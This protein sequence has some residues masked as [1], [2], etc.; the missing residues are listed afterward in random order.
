[1]GSKAQKA[2]DQCR[3]RKIKCDSN[4]L[5]EGIPCTKC[6]I[7]ELQCTYTYMR[8][9][10]KPNIAKTQ[11]SQ[12]FDPHSLIE[13]ILSSA[14]YTLPS[15]TTIVHDIIVSLANYARSVDN[16]LKRLRK[17]MMGDESSLTLGNPSSQ[18]F[19]S[20]PSDTNMSGE[21]SS[22]DDDD[23][24]EETFK[25]ITLGHS[26]VRHFGKSSNMRFI[27]D[28]IT[29]ATKN[30]QPLDFT[31]HD[32]YLARFKRPEYWGLDMWK[33]QPEIAAPIYTFPEIDLLWDLLRIYFTEVAPYFP[34]LHRPTFEK[35]VINGRH[36]LDHSFGALLLAV[37]AVAA[38][39]SQD[40]RILKQDTK[41][42]AGWQ[43]FSQIRLVRPN[44]VEPTSIHEL[45]LYCVAYLYLRQ[46]NMFDSAWSLVGLGLRLSLDRGIHRLK[47]NK[48]RDAESELWIRIFWILRNADVLQGLSLGRPAAIDS[49]HFDLDRPVECDDEYWEKTEHNEGFTQ[50]PGKT[51]GLSFFTHYNKLVD[52]AA[53]V[54]RSVYCVNEVPEYKDDS[55]T[56]VERNR[57]KAMQHDSAL[58][59]W[60]MSLPEHLRWDPNQPDKIRLNHSAILYTTFYWIQLQLHK[61]FLFRQAS[62]S[63]NQQG[64]PSF[65]ICANAARSTVRI[66]QVLHQRSKNRFEVLL[67]IAHCATFLNLILWRHRQGTGPTPYAD[68][69]V[70]RSDVT[71]IVEMLTNADP[72]AQTVGRVA[73]KLKAFISAGGLLS[74][75][76]V[77][78]A[79]TSKRMRRDD[80]DD[81]DDSSVELN[82]ESQLNIPEIEQRRLA[83]T[84]RVASYMTNSQIMIDPSE[85]SVLNTS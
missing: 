74:N 54:Q 65:A 1:M 29:N 70:V 15:D 57:K 72:S 25:K 9:K 55:L 76:S 53:S 48:S 13:E 63:D 47:T 58:N 59:H 31:Q 10:R 7:A 51:S 46:T 35:A 80:M 73:D 4:N 23:V 8:K 66:S 20:S 11:S 33:F 2:C 14:A 43:W 56:A 52:I 77:E 62:A 50:P 81:M 42:T 18:L 64:F 67:N 5:Q 41:I 60:L 27:H 68:I 37:C 26:N 85:V 45:Q 16:E 32:L 75:V 28:I 17:A 36:L 34:L 38:R 49:E 69:K 24:N 30:N 82:F 71:S 44:F 78:S 19:G 61:N 6:V 83:G 84:Q 21:D 12:S 22:S 39:D 3:S 40:P 79:P